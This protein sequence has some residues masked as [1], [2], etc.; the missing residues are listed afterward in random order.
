MAV[1]L[2]A[3]TVSLGETADEAVQDTIN[4]IGAGDVGAL[5]EAVPAS[6]QQD[7]SRLVHTAAAKM[8]PVVWDR[9]FAVGKKLASVMRARKDLMFAAVET[10]TDPQDAEGFKASIEGTIDILSLVVNSEISKLEN[11]RKLDMGKFAAG[12][13]SKI[14]KR[15]MAFQNAVSIG[16]MGMTELASMKDAKVTLVGMENGVATLS[17]EMRDP[18]EP[19][20]IARS[21]TMPF[22]QVDGKWTPQPMVALWPTWVA[23]AEVKIRAMKRLDEAQVQEFL[24]VADAID[25]QL[26]TLAEVEDSE[27]FGMQLEMVQMS[28]M[29]LFVPFQQ[30]YS[31]DTQTQETQTPEQSD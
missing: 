5:W 21:A 31:Q 20:K 17:L 28:I 29:G 24:A 11:V 9:S 3:S 18:E 13:G 10:G 26:D 4:R 15:A 22:V 16:V 30:M 25:G 8:D 27:Q 2:A 14:G 12:T 1:L 23:Q 19:D 6:Y 7:I